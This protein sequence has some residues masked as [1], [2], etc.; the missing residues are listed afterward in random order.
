VDTQRSKQVEALFRRALAQPAEARPAFLAAACPDRELRREVESLLARSNDGQIDTEGQTAAGA[1]MTG[2]REPSALTGRRFGVYLI[3]SLVG[4]GGMGEVYCARDTRLGRDVAIKILPRTVA[5]DRDR[6]ARFEREARLLAALNH[7]HIA[8][9]HGIEE[10]NGILAL[11]MELV[12][13]ETL[14][15]WIARRSTVRGVALHPRTPTPRGARQASAVVNDALAIARQIVEALD[16]AHEKGIVHRDLKPANVKI[17]S[18]GTVK[19][20]DFGLAKAPA[21]D[22][23]SALS[24][25]P[26]TAANATAEGLILGTVPYMSPEGP[27]PICRQENRY[28]GVRVRAVRDVDRSCALCARDHLRHRRGDPRP[29]AC[30][31]GAAQHRATRAA[32]AVETVPREGFETTTARHRRRTSLAGRSSPAGR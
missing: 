30:L 11:V 19:V 25:A 21:S 2:G 31:G 27:G 1:H 24:Q 17:T 9:I 14:A 15:E 29:R 16:A 6:I 5:S 13:G 28:L 4:A 3:Q 8:T 32:A 22:H 10:S 18:D 20:L 23:G 12:E 26:T 7:P